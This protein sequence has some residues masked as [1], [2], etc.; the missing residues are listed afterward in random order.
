VLKSGVDHPLPTK[1]RFCTFDTILRV[2]EALG[3]ELHAE[4]ART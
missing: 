3:L 4:P 1:M 2:V